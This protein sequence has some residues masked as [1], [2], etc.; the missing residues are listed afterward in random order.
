MAFQNI[1]GTCRASLYLYNT[2]DDIDRLIQGLIKVKEIFS[3]VL[4]R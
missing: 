3:R 2:K 1:P 4:K